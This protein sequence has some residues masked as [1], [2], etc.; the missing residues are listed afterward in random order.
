MAWVKLDD[1]FVIHAKSLMV[2][3]EGTWLDLAAISHCN[4][5]H[6][7]GV[8][9]CDVVRSFGLQVGMSRQK[10]DT[11]IR[12]LVD[13]GRWHEPSH[14]C[15]RCVEP[16]SGHLVIHDYLEYQPSAEASHRKSA[17]R[18]SAGRRGGIE[19]GRARREA[20]ASRLLPHGEAN[21]EANGEAR[22]D[23]SRPVSITSS[24]NSRA[25][26]TSAEGDDHHEPPALPD[27]LWRLVA[28][29]QLKRQAIGQV[30]DPDKWLQTAA[31]NAEN[32]LGARAAE[33]WAEFDISP[34]QLAE[35][36]ASGTQAPAGWNT[37]RRRQDRG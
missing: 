7:D 27:D 33:L 16:R 22:P 34:S 37:Q 20:N 10:V 17:A 32:R 26:S 23:P 9:S 5:F 3:P 19:S 31:E 24:L 8:L 35:V 25:Y 36:L 29:K 21:G 12:R 14:Q 11:L 28:Q 2:G 4:R 30:R 18:A 1:G 6:T 15:P 13:A